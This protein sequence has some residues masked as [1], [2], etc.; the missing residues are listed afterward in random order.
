MEIFPVVMMASRLYMMVSIIQ[1]DQLDKQASISVALQCLA[2]AGWILISID[3]IHKG[4]HGIGLQWH[5]TSSLRCRQ[6]ERF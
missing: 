5:H 1:A 2:A 4:A 6:R 3:A